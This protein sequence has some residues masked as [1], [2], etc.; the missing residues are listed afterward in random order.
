[1]WEKLGINTY[2]LT[3][4]HPVL[5]F[6]TL[7]GVGTGKYT[8]KMKH[9]STEALGISLEELPFP[10]L[11]HAGGKLLYWNTA[12]AKALGYKRND[13]P[14][15]SSFRPKKGEALA[16]NGSVKHVTKKGEE[17]FFEIKRKTI[18]VNKKKAFIESLVATDGRSTNKKSSPV[19]H[20]LTEAFKLANM[21][22]LSFLT[23]ETVVISDELALL[24]KR[25]TLSGRQIDL[26]EFVSTG[27]AQED[28]ELF[29]KKLASGKQSKIT[30]NR[31]SFQLDLT[32]SLK[33]IR[34]M[35]VV[36][37][38]IKS[39]PVSVVFQDITELL[40]LERER[41]A[42][43]IDSVATGRQLKRLLY[44]ITDGVFAMDRKLCITMVNPVFESIAGVPS[45]S[46]IGK[47]ILEIFPGFEKTELYEKYKEAIRTGE[48]FIYESVYPEISDRVYEVNGYPSLEGIFVYFR[49]ITLKKLTAEKLVQLNYELKDFQAAITNS[50]IVSRADVQG[51]I[52]YVNQNFVDISGYSGDELVG[53]NHRIIN[54]SYHPKTFWV[55]MWKTISSGKTWRAEVK[56]RAKDGS[57]Y[58]VDT[59]VMPFLDEQGKVREYLSIRNDITQR[60]V[61]EESIIRLNQSLLDFENAIQGSSI[62]S[63]ADKAGTITYVNQ[64]FVDISGYSVEEL[65][66]Q[67][68]RIINSSYHPKSFWVDMWK[69]I[70]AG[71]TWR[72]EVRNKAK[73]GSY[74][75]VDTFVMPFL[76]PDGSVREFLSI[77]NDITKRKL[78]EEALERSNSSLSETLIFGKM[79]SAT[80]MLQTM[81]LCVSKELY[82]LLDVEVTEAQNVPL[83]EFVQAYINPAD[84]SIIQ[85]KIAEGISGPE[86]MKNVVALEFE[87][88]TATE[89]KI[90]IHAKGIF[91]GALAFGLLHDVSEK[92]KAEDA[93]AENWAGY[94]N[95]FEANPLPMWIF[96]VKTLEFVE[97][98][99]AAI[100]KY[101]YSREDFAAMTMIDLKREEDR[102]PFYQSVGYADEYTHISHT[103]HKLKNN[104]VID[105][106]AFV[107]KIYYQG[108][109]CHFCVVIDISE[110]LAAEYE[111]RKSEERF[112]FLYNNTP[113]LMHSI[114]A[115]GNLIRVSDFW[116]QKME[117]SR[118]EV[119]G[120]PFASFLTKSSRKRSDEIILPEFFKT[121]SV[122]NE[123][124]DFVTKSGKV[125]HTLLSATTEY[126]EQGKIFKSLAVVT[127]VT[128]K[129]LLELEVS[130][131]AAISQRTSN[132]VVLTD[133]EGNVTWVNHGFE[134]ISG[135]TQ[136]EVLGSKPGFFLQGPETDKNT[137]ARISKAIQ[138]RRGIKEEI[139]NYTKSGRTYWLDI[140][141]MPTFNE[142][143]EVNGFMA[144]QS[145]I[146]D[147]KKALLEMQRSEQTLQTFMDYAPL[148]AF[149]KD[150]DGRYTFF[151][152]MYRDFMKDKKLVS[153]QTDYDLFDKDFA[154]LCVDRDQHIIRTGETLQFEH[155]VGGRMF[156]EYKFPLRD[157]FQNIFA[158]GG[159]S[160]DITEKLEA[161]NAIAESEEKFKSL[162]RDLN[163]GVLLQGTQAEILLANEAACNLVGLTHDQ[164]LGKTSFDP[165]WQL[166]REDGTPFTLAELPVPQVIEKKIA[167]RGV[168]MSVYKPTQHSRVWLSIDVIPR[169]DSSG[170]VKN[171][172]CTLYDVTEIKNAQAQLIESESRF[173]T[174]SSEL[175]TGVLL[176]GVHDEV[177]FSNKA[178]LDLLGISED[179]LL[180]KT[181]FDPDWKVIHEDG[182]PFMPD[183]RPSVTA[184][185][186]KQRVTNIPM[187]IFRPATNDW[188]WV[189]VSAVP[190]LD[191][192]GE[193][194]QT[195][196]SMADITEHKKLSKQ[197]Y[198]SEA[199]QRQILNSMING[200]VVVDSK[201][202]I[203]YANQGAIEILEFD[204]DEILKLH[205]TSPDW[206]RV[207]EDGNLIPLEKL[208][209][210]IVLNQRRSV[211]NIEHGIL[212]PKGNIKWLNV[213][214]SPLIDEQ[215]NLIGAVA[216]FLDV[217]QQKQA[218]VNLRDAAARLKIATRTAGMGVWEWNLITDETIYDDVLYELI[219]VEKNASLTYQKFREYILNEDRDRIESVI[220]NALHNKLA[221]VETVMRIRHGK[222]KEIRHFLVNAFIIYNKD[223][224]AVKMIGVD[225]DITERERDQRELK[226]LH[227]QL[228]A[229]LNASTEATFFL[230]HHYSI[231][232]LNKTAELGIHKVWN[233]QVKLGDSMLEYIPKNMVDDFR[234]N[235]NRALLGEG[236]NIE[237]EIDLNNKERVWNQ[238]R[239]LPV[240]NS[241]GTIIGVSFNT[242]NISARKKAEQ[243]LIQ[244]NKQ[245]EIAANLANM[246]E[247]E[248]DLSTMTPFWS[249][250][251]CRI[252]EV[253]PGYVPD[254]QT[255]L[256]F[257][258]PESRDVIKNAVQ[259]CAE[260]GK[261]YDLEL[262]I[263][264]AKGKRREI[265][266]IG[267]AEI[268]NGKPVK[269]FG[270]FQ[271][272]TQQKQTEAEIIKTSRLFEVTSNINQ[273]MVHAVSKDEVFLAACHIAVTFGKFRMAWV[274]VVDY[275]TGV[276][277]PVAFDGFVNGY[278]ESIQEIS[279]LD[280]PAGKGPTGRAAREKMTFI[281]NNIADPEDATYSIWRTEALK[282]NYLSSIGI[283]IM[284]ESRV[285]AVF[286]LYHAEPFFFSDVEINLL[287]KVASNI[288]FSI[289]TIDKEND[290]RQ[291]QKELIESENRF[292]H[293]FEFSPLPTWVFDEATLKFLDVNVAAINHYGYLKEDFFNMT[294]MDIR[295]PEDRM[296]LEDLMVVLREERAKYL[297]QGPE[298]Y[299]GKSWKH[300]KKNGAVIDVE[301]M[302]IPINY[303]EIKAWL[304]NVNDVTEVLQNQNRLIRA[305]TEKELLIKEIHHRVKNNLQ[306]ISSILYLKLASFES[307]EVKE[308]L[309]GMR[310][311]I[312]SISLIHERLLQTGMVDKIE[313]QHYLQSLVADIQ[314]GFYRKDLQLAL[315][316]DID[317]IQVPSDTAMYCGLIINELVTNSIKYAFPD[318]DTGVI[319]ITLREIA[320][321]EL[322]LKVSDNGIG[323]P[324]TVNP[325]QAN[326][327]GM[328]LLNVFIQQLKGSL[329]ISRGNGTE[330]KINFEVW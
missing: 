282:R 308:F 191:I 25:D 201:G 166:L 179:Q 287:N 273:M 213:N 32:T 240:F 324:E 120:K 301:I 23:D 303:G 249:D 230:D 270:L 195:I 148:V 185:K 189:L 269:L 139:L 297:T 239:Y 329:E 41:E 89:R 192:R 224:E 219:G 162:I 59:F 33:H 49:D 184:S 312:R 181:S 84:H 99:N 243:N 215:G 262:S 107:H 156:L 266:T 113:A 67:N 252:H 173:R 159:L 151:N 264:T 1:L 30:P 199:R 37:L 8:E 296:R 216:S 100:I 128:E 263:V 136:A 94:K 90:K 56:N 251:V 325:A 29:F 227:D 152:K 102:Q 190:I 80:L 26:K 147:L 64:N 9:K 310:E 45:T 307:T 180:G 321:Q 298:I 295:P 150:N 212:D 146:T 11:I 161:Q 207:D 68:H 2:V 149:V 69:T 38:F 171:V 103:R 254:L 137:V 141:I 124:Y 55:D 318:K 72:A 7:L 138:E 93:L 62:V 28:Q 143:G 134:R 228:S 40:Q 27:I 53:H 36:M 242:A 6:C 114:D 19:T 226:R 70:A 18:V 108:R 121:G 66:G 268:S 205:Y 218:D 119:L 154:D 142:A 24:L 54:S 167:V 132:A 133:V 247:W 323:L 12:A 265:R 169:L 168:I 314:I 235:F 330:F 65:V 86:G 237:R 14:A 261:P 115:E 95:L 202:A 15:L 79:G 286:T 42:A 22:M 125:L 76:N 117:Y 153:G 97:V 256:D 158:I 317:S 277:K 51:N 259:G 196:V 315:D 46:A 178:A 129:K 122:N 291:K 177:L 118:E 160:I 164:L 111:L 188:V 5:D 275:K 58:W 20:H 83:E 130:K 231:Q 276:I 222:T 290:R 313:T 144:I 305:L 232:V 78:A 74:Y 43:V 96:D 258:T 221:T 13:R 123:E 260:S 186:T 309:S 217:T 63:R 48:P 155:H 194:K 75:W 283:P 126:D 246:G 198:E 204:V 209:L 52:T 319:K 311:K 39:K 157:A 210:Y 241:D 165:D 272:I 85:Q 91:D 10:T 238:I 244:K 292:R 71:Q 163:V 88:I 112:R 278:F 250:E 61:Q 302:S 208:P 203:T 214:A 197:V 35:E 4:S 82:H 220:A 236:V 145:D 271:D 60:K 77:R 234:R 294:I 193:I 21:G 3:P 281:N 116:L 140:E 285:I 257:Y 274:G 225:Y 127:D 280:V 176:Q 47:S 284:V 328:Q 98:N 326:S 31:I 322:E 253:K 183:D 279:S 109:D 16:G 104:T 73:N 200:V 175:N 300:I 34:N 293:L 87:M 289:L 255:A 223:G 110:R 17:K 248:V 306:L 57:Y 131:L 233:K 44:S 206:K 101:G 229:V 172:V 288:A 316:I 135:F 92:K 211:S 320:P 327:F 170:N 299:R 182:S 267:L 50:S 304:V 245:I 174:L 105:V 187:G 106:E 81:Q